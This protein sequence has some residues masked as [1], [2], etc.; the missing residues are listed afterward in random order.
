[1]LLCEA[2]ELLNALIELSGIISL[3]GEAVDY[4][5]IAVEEELAEVP[6]D[7]FDVQADT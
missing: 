3:I 2:E 4:A 5:T 7:L 6:W 1:M